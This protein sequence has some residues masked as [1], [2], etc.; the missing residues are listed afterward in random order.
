ME[1]ITKLVKYVS[2]YGNISKQFA[3]KFLLTI[4]EKN[5]IFS[6]PDEKQEIIIENLITY[7]DTIIISH[8]KLGVISNKQSKHITKKEI[9][10]HL[11]SK[12]FNLMQIKDN[13]KRY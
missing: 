1:K 4:F 6:L 10:Y 13:L 2:K 7:F 8:D 9:F 3:A 5:D 12:T 11:E